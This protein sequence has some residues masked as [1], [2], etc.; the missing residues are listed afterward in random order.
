[1]SRLHDMK[2]GLQYWRSHQIWWYRTVLGREPPV[3]DTRN[4]NER[5]DPC[6]PNG[7]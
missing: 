3:K 2:K 1:M 6:Y 4:C 7:R 5:E